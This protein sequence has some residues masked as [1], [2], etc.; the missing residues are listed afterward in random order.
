ML[1]RAGAP[2][3]DRK[4][5]GTKLWRSG[6]RMTNQIAKDAPVDARI[7]PIARPY[8]ATCREVSA[9][10]NSSSWS[11]RQHSNAMQCFS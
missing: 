2:A 8:A 7:G 1:P 6:Q 11:V 9:L 10:T 4:A 3:I 5:P